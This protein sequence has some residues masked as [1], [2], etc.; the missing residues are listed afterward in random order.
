MRKNQPN[1]IQVFLFY[2]FCYMIINPD[3]GNELYEL[4]EPI[5]AISIK[6]GFRM[7]LEICMRGH[8]QLQREQQNTY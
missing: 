8:T 7:L 5:N 2:C 6:I 4:I 3:I 1:E